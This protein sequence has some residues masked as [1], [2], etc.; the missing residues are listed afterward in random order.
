MLS[1]S[2]IIYIIPIIVT[3]QAGAFIYFAGRRNYLNKVFFLLSVLIVLWNVE[4][5]ATHMSAP[6]RNLISLGG[7]L[8]P[9]AFLQF[10]LGLVHYST[11]LSRGIIFFGYIWGGILLAMEISPLL[12]LREYLKFGFISLGSSRIFIYLT[13]FMSYTLGAESILFRAAWQHRGDPKAK[14]YLLVALAAFAAIFG[15]VLQAGLLSSPLRYWIC[16]LINL[17]YVLVMGWAIWRYEVLEISPRLRITSVYSVVMTLVL[18]VYLAIVQLFSTLLMPFSWI[19]PLWV[20]L[21]PTLVVG[22]LFYSL[23]EKMDNVVKKYFPLTQDIYYDKLRSFSQELASLVPLEDVAGKILTFIS[24]VFDIRHAELVV[25]GSNGAL[26]SWR[27]S[28]EDELKIVEGC[29]HYPGIC[30]HGFE[31]VITIPIGSRE[32]TVGWLK[33]GEPS[34]GTL[35]KDD[36]ELIKSFLGQAGTALHNALLFSELSSLIRHY[37]ALLEGTVNGVMVLDERL[38]IITMNPV[39]ARMFGVVA[40]QVK[41][42]YLP[43]LPGAQALELMIAQLKQGDKPI[44]N[45]EGF[46]GPDEAKVPVQINLFSFTENEDTDTPPSIIIVL[47]DLTERKETEKQWRRTE[48]LAAMGRLTTGLAHELRNGLNK[49]GGFAAILEDLVAGQPDLEYYAKGIQEDVHDL[50]GFLNK[51]LTFARERDYN[52]TKVKLVDILKRDLETLQREFSEVGVRVVEEYQGEPCVLGDRHLLGLAIFNLL[53]NAIQ[54]LAGMDGGVV[55]IRVYEEGS[56]C[57]VEIQ[58]NGPG[59]P[60]V[61]Q[62]LI[63]DP[64]YTTKETGTGLGLPTAYKIIT[65]HNGNLTLKS[66]VGEGTIFTIELPKYTQ[67][68]P[69]TS[70]RSEAVTD[71]NT[72][73]NSR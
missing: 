53:A 5:L 58:D 65:G 21:L 41:N 64:F 40:E 18:L 29:F 39:A 70:K 26:R 52:L 51:F 8:L 12:V 57:F 38:R 7:I 4:G 1:L 16:S 32:Q 60:A 71:E 6:W 3:L 11:G 37:E 63:F 24:K 67:D 72:G 33:L 45:T 25:S 35:T 36:Q 69:D 44:P 30:I 68:T 23:R 42:R 46:V 73:S 61:K 59:I 13:Y 17:A 34:R 49:I 55:T 56:A 50:A 28:R 10:S 27:L 47:A 48:R 15:G 22:P 62:E 2:V 43:E 20:G 19:G 14:R 54:A 9:V 66:E 31:H